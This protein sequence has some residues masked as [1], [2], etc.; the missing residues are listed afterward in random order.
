[1]MSD[2]ESLKQLKIISRRFLA[3]FSQ[4]GKLFIAIT[5]MITILVTPAFSAKKARQVKLR[6]KLKVLARQITHVRTQLKETKQQQR[7]I[8]DQLHVT[9][10]RLNDNQ[11]KLVNVRLKIEMTSRQI[12]SVSARL[13][14]TEAQL[15]EHN[16][17]LACRLRAIYRHGSV[18]YASVLLSSRS[19]ADYTDRKYY[20]SRVVNGDV[21]LINQIKQE[22]REVREYKATLVSKQQD[23][24][25]YKA[26]LAQKNQEIAQE[27]QEKQ[28]ILDRVENQRES[29]EQA[30]SELEQASNEIENSIRAFQNTPRGRL[31]AARPFRGGFIR[32]VAGRVTSGFGY[33]VHP[34]LHIAKLHTGVDLGARYGT[35]IKAAASGVVIHAGWW[36]AYGNAV[37][38]DHGGGVSTLYGHCSLLS[39][40]AGQNVSQGDIIGKVGSTG[41]STGAHLHFEVRR[42]GTPVSPF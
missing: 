23:L 33:R 3:M 7:K 11:Q 19:F 17:L 26:Q 16:Q 12:Q 28:E 20:V 42:N 14:K 34:I 21:S 27:A 4:R 29:Y 36:G 1:M 22:T 8:S 10:V 39:V 32:P 9:E 38:I 5:L 40:H 41:W 31:R 30:L 37:I 35:S 15:K 18:S 13:K 2:F 6:A 24:I 25:S